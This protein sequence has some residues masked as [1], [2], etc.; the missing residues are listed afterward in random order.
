M[1]YFFSGPD[2]LYAYNFF[3]NASVY[4]LCGIE[5]IGPLPQVEN[6][7][8]QTLG[9]SLNSMR[10]SL[11]SLLDFSF[12]ITKKMRTDLQ[13]SRLSGTL[14]LLYIFLARSGCRIHDVTFTGLDP[15][16]NFTSARTTAPAVRIDFASQS[17]K[18]QT[19]FYF[20]TDLSDGP[21]DRS[22]L[23][24]WCG[25]LGPARGLVKSASYLMHT[26]D[27]DTVRK[28]LMA[29]CDAIL[30]DDSG[31]PVRLFPPDDWTI[32]LFGAYHAPINTFKQYVQPELTQL[33]A[34][35]KSVPLPFSIGYTWHPG[36]SS[37]ILAVKATHANATPTPTPGALPQP[38]PQPSAQP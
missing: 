5:P 37:V 4:V 20:S 36:Q 27:F 17:G 31:I 28:F 30:Q 23:L 25:T 7:P 9:D 3:P 32:H 33:T 21:V 12:F 13:D 38:S 16:G 26:D 6:L 1:L 35:Q 10:D 22:G 18:E 11:N 8:P 2:F 29:D 14:P 19:L 24:A 34:S 15:K